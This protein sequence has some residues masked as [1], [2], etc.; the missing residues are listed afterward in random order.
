METVHA[1]SPTEAPARYGWRRSTPR[2]S[3]GSRSHGNPGRAS[4]RPR[5]ERI[6]SLEALAAS[7]ARHGHI[8][9]MIL[10][11]FVPHPRY[12]GQGGR[13][14]R[15]RGCEAQVGVR[16]RPAA[17]GRA[18]TKVSRPK[19]QA[20]SRPGRPRSALDDMKR[21]VAE[22]RRLM[23]DVGIQIPPEPRRLVGRAGRGRGHRPRRPLGQ[24]RPHLARARLPEPARG[25]Q[26][27]G[28]AGLRADRA[29]V[30]LSAIPGCRV[31]RAGG[32]RRGQAQVL[33]LHPAH[34]AR[35][36]EPSGRSIPSWRRRRSSAAGAARR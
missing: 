7:H 14:D 32:S 35:A 2:A 1:G 12:Y 9:E 33:E 31:G 26:A 13:R 15:R 34:G 10:Q 29:P 16:W 23:P 11:N 36:G 22:T 5:T 8:Q 28:T 4:A 27:P 20:A 19:P 6:A 17:G 3:C 18:R 25:P 30:R 24:R 21:L